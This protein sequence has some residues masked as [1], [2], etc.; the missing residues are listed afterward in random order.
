[1]RELTFFSRYVPCSG[2]TGENLVEPLKCEE[3]KWYEGKMTLVEAIDTFTPPP[4]LVDKP[5]RYY[6]PVGLINL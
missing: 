5:F 3:G 1:M 2:L 4:R 6:H